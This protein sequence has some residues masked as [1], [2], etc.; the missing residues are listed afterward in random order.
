MASLTRLADGTGPVSSGDSPEFTHVGGLQKPKREE[1]T[2]LDEC[3]FKRLY[4]VC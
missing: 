2:P 1:Q 4:H 3:F